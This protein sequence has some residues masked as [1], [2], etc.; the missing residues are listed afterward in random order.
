MSVSK[1]EALAIAEEKLVE[2]YGK[3]ILNQRPFQVS[4]DDSSWKIK[5]TLQCAKGTVCKGGTAFI[6]IDKNN[7][8]V[9]QAGHYR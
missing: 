2:K 8:K 5:G 1:N 9:I 4:E 6:E 3:K 7:G